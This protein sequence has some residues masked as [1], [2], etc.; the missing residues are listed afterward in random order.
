MVRLYNTALEQEDFS[1]LFRYI[2]ESVFIDEL[3]ERAGP[4]QLVF[5]K[6]LKRNATLWRLEAL[7][8]PRMLGNAN[9]G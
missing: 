9:T 6:T 4:E 2:E 1:S 8:S 3:I 5:L 7:L